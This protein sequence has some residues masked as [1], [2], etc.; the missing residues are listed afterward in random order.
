MHIQSAGQDDQSPQ[1]RTIND[2]AEILSQIIERDLGVY[3]PPRK[4]YLFI[5]D[6]WSSLSSLAH[7]IHRDARD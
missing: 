3:I 6:Y 5:R 4:L 7:M 1:T 2:P